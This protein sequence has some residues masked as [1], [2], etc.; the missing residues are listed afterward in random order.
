MRAKVQCQ[1]QITAATCMFMLTFMS[2]VA[3]DMVGPLARTLAIDK[4]AV[5]MHLHQ[6]ACTAL[7]PG[8]A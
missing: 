5:C 6:I 1:R 7:D 4:S 2:L 8:R 3:G